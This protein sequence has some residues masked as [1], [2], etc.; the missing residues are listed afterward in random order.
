MIK[1]AIPCASATSGIVARGEI[2]RILHRF[3]CK[4]IEKLSQGETVA[5]AD[6]SVRG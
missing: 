6:S 5:S 1:S 3:G 4:S 2:T